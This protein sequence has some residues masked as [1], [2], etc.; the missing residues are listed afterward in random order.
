MLRLGAVVCLLLITCAA[1]AGDRPLPDDEAVAAAEKIVRE[2]YDAELATEDGLKSVIKAADAIADDD[3]GQVAMLVAIER[4]ATALGCY[5]LGF[6]AAQRIEARYDCEP[7]SLQIEYLDMVV[8]AAK[9]TP[10]RASVVNQAMELADRAQGAGDLEGA[11]K[12]IKVAQS[13]VGRL[14]DPALRKEVA[15]KRREIDKQAKDR[16]HAS[17]E[18][19]AAL[20]RLKGDPNNAKDSETVGRDC[21]RRGDWAT[22][23]A[24]LTSAESQA[25]RKAAV[26]DKAG[27]DTSEAQAKVGDLWWTAGAAFRPRAVFWY[28]RAVAGATGLVKA[29]LEKR[30]KE[31]GDVPA[32]G[33]SLATGGKSADIVLAPGVVLKMVQ[34]PASP[35][36]K[37]SAFWLGQT[38]VTEAQWAA[39]MGGAVQTPAR[40]K[41]RLG[42]DDCERFVDRLGEGGNFRFRFRLPTNDELQHAWSAGKPADLKLAT[43]S[44]YAWTK[45]NSRDAFHNVAELE[46]NALG[47]F[48]ISGNV[49]EWVSKSMVVGGGFESP[50]EA[51]C[52]RLAMSG[53]E[54]AHNPDHF[55]IRIAADSR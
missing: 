37:V 5:R 51:C 33:E 10:Q 34:V 24:F 25:V 32:G 47:L 17:K 8:K 48:D 21:A 27:A 49:W 12:A 42:F 9:T 41:G 23:L 13:F 44:K 40:P 18:V 52:D 28:T 38:E 19:D 54:T 31:A 22:A 35:D 3:A 14:R 46:P 1:L 55:G 7:F 29:R 6:A 26:A 50:D 43:L 4:R 2:T 20:D 11:E 15:A 39:V 36:G 53:D 45:G 30:I 16:D